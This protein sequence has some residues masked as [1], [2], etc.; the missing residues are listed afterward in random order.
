MWLPGVYRDD[1]TLVLGRDLGDEL[2]KRPS[3][4]LRMD[5]GERCFRAVV[6]QHGAVA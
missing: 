2:N 1:G 6:G 3:L 5:V 4:N